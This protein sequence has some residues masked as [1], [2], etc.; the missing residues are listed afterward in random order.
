MELISVQNLDKGTVLSR[1]YVCQKK[2]KEKKSLFSKKLVMHLQTFATKAKLYKNWS[3]EVEKITKN[4]HIFQFSLERLQKPC[5]LLIK[6]E[7]NRKR[8]ILEKYIEIKPLI[9]G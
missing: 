4:V 2:K 6:N 5:K 9:F 3:A 7:G 8:H 1:G